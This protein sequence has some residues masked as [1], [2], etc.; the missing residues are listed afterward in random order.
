[1][2]WGEQEWSRAL[3]YTT[4]KP[5]R[6]A[7][8]EGVKPPDVPEC[9][10]GPTWTSEAMSVL[11]RFGA[12]VPFEDAAVV[13]AFPTS[14]VKPGWWV[15]AYVSSQEGPQRPGRHTIVRGGVLGNRMSAAGVERAAREA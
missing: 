11:T 10:V 4:K 7:M 6:V 9:A 13:A 12:C 3:Q 1:M 2:R 15:V 5:L 8:V 14:A